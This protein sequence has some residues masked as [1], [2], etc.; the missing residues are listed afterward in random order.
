MTYHNLYTVSNTTSTKLTE[1]GV[2]SGKDITLQNA[3]DSGIIY[4]GAEGVTSS[5]FGYRLLPNHAIS[6][7]LSGEDSLYAIA[8]TNN[9][10]L[11]SLAINLETGN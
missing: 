11:A 8:D 3:N 1:A 4:I 10:L 5:S 6:F 9:L 2:H 7:E